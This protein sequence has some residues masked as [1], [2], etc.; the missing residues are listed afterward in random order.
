MTTKRPYFSSKVDDVV[1]KLNP[2]RKK[3]FEPFAVYLAATALLD[4]ESNRPRS[5]FVDNEAVRLQHAL[6]IGY[7]R[8]LCDVTSCM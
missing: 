8:E 5:A 1:G 7:I 4:S 2:Q 3:I 6:Q